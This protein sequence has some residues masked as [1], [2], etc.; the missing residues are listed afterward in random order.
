MIACIGPVT[1]QTAR[2][3]GLKVDVVAARH[4]VKGLVQALKDHLKLDSEA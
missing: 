1:A 2:D 3:L 4:T